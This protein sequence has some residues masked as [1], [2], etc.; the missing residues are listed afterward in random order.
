MIP[1]FLLSQLVRQHCTVALGGDGGDELF[2]GYRHYSRLLWMQTHLGRLPLQLR[3]LVSMMAERL[4]PVGMKGRNWLQGLG[5][6][7]QQGLPLKQ[8]VKGVC[9][10][11]AS[12]SYVLLRCLGSRGYAHC[13]SPFSRC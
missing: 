3:L 1:T 5:V 6:D 4:L 7:L 12:F 13:P 8:Y 10:C 9:R 2:G 11:R